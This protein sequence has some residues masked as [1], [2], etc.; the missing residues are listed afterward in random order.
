MTNLGECKPYLSCLT[1]FSGTLVLHMGRGE[2]CSG[3]NA[4]WMSQFEAW[5]A[6]QKLLL[7]G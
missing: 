5:W 4:A 1:L 3:L 2:Y 6:K 7:L